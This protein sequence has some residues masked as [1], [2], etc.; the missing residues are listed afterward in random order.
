MWFFGYLSRLRIFHKQRH[1]AESLRVQGMNKSRTRSL[2]GELIIRRLSVT[3][4]TDEMWRDRRADIAQ[5]VAFN[6]AP[7]WDWRHT[8]F[9][10]QARRLLMAA[11][12]RQR[13]YYDGS[14]TS[15]FFGRITE[16]L[17]ALIVMNRGGR[18]S[19]PRP[20][21]PGRAG[22]F[23]PGEGLTRLYLHVMIRYTLAELKCIIKTANINLN[24]RIPLIHQ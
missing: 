12:R 1:N 14:R 5:A 9:M 15:L 16:E 22:F 17:G 23:G 7:S 2:G 4:D 19:G 10:P 6:R 24:Y 18:G 20:L 21:G 13:I 8:K 3:K 11:I